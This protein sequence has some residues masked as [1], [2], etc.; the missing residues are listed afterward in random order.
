MISIHVKMDL[1]PIFGPGRDQGNRPT[2]LAFAASDVH[3]ALRGSW[4]P[5]SCEYAIYHAQRRAGRPPDAGAILPAMLEAIR[6]DGQPPESAWPYLVSI[7]PNPTLWQPPSGAGPIFRRAGDAHAFAV[8][9]IV[10]QLDGGVPVLVL[11]N[12]SRS[13]FF[14]GPDGLVD[15]APGEPPD[16]H[17]RHAVVAVGHGVTGARRVILVRNSWGDAWGVE[18]HA[19]ITEEFL[20]P[21]VFQLAVLKEDLS[22]PSSSAAA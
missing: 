16:H 15:Q 9:A 6:M 14:V 19:W 10:G 11:M 7:P 8:D 3:A 17:R 5:L 1:R 22:V 2:C 13:F 12:L 21:R 18:G 4:L 20:A